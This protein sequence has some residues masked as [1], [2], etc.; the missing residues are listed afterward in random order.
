MVRL[1]PH[2]PRG[3]VASPHLVHLPTFHC[4]QVLPSQL[5]V[6]GDNRHVAPLLAAGRSFGLRR[7]TDRNTWMETQQ[8][9]CMVLTFIG[10]LTVRGKLNYTVY[11]ASF[12]KSRSKLNSIDTEANSDI[13]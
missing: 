13:V 4:P 3:A 2:L 9:E 6:I 7:R 12:N 5:V 1:L 10:G 11:K 8:A